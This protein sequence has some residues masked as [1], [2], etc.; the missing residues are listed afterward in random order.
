MILKT[1]IAGAKELR[2]VLVKLPDRARKRVLA[3]STRKAA[4]VVL[5]ETVAQ[6]PVGTE[7]P[8]FKYGRL[9]DNLR[10]TAR[11]GNDADKAVFAVH[12]GRAYWANFLE[13]GTRYMAARPFMRHAMEV[14][15][16]KA[17]K[18]L[19]DALGKGIEKEAKTLAGP[20]A[21]A[22]KLFKGLR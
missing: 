5:D 13:F 1:H 2:A 16:P 20:Y 3:S 4:K 12:N 10:V 21:K 18:V 19:G 8:D 15:V 14:S 11:K 9:R 17:L 7:P 6:A 22:R